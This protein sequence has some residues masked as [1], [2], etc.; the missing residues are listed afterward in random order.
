MLDNKFSPAGSEDNIINFVKDNT[1]HSPFNV[2]ANV[3]H[4]KALAF[5]IL[6]N[7]CFHVSYVMY[8]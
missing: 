5:Y 7:I 6:D 4:L 2:S 8:I 1:S 3:Y